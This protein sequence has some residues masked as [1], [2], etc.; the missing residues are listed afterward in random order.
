VSNNGNG[1]T[2]SPEAASD[3]R[4]ALAMIGHHARLDP[5][6]I[7]AVLDEAI[8]AGRATELLIAIVDVYDAI[9]P[10]FR[11]E[12]AMACLSQCVEMVHDHGPVDWRRAAAV[13]MARSTDDTDRFNEAIVEANDDGRTGELVLAMLNAYALLLPEL[14]TALG[15]EALSKWTARIAGVEAAADN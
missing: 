5:A 4:R 15:L 8:G 1:N 6:G 11:T 14:G 7:R 10:I 2:I 12:E 13:I 3:A 9:V